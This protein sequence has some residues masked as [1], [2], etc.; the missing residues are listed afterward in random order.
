MAQLSNRQFWLVFRSRRTASSKT[1]LRPRRQRAHSY[2]FL[3]FLLCIFIIV[4]KSENKLFHLLKSIVSNYVV[5]PLVV[6]F[7]KN[8]K[9]TDFIRVNGN[10]CLCDGTET[11]S[12]CWVLRKWKH[13]Q[14]FLTL[15]I[16][17]LNQ[18]LRP[19]NKRP[20]CGVYTQHSSLIYGK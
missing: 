11:S 7:H 16:E 18:W 10:L 3:L 9:S 12:T 5:F 20:H 6:K 14:H 8:Q 1:V 13:F 2:Y 4:Y 19:S 17:Q 15:D